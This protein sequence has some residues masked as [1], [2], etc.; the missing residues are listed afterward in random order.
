MT[1]Q[2]QLC[3]SFPKDVQDGRKVSGYKKLVPQ[4]TPTEFI[5]A[6]YVG[7]NGTC[8][9]RME[10]CLDDALHLNEE[11]PNKV[12][13]TVKGEFMRTLQ[14]FRS[15]RHKSELKDDSVLLEFSLE[16]NFTLGFPLQLMSW[17]CI[18]ND[19]TL[20]ISI[21]HWQKNNPFVSLWTYSSNEIHLYVFASYEW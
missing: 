14:Y 12:Q 4:K 21:G 19:S 15:S 13:I 17:K 6:Y 9:V 3:L 5:P 18:V 8:Y 7:D 2:F 11:A 16:V 20:A 10:L 1:S